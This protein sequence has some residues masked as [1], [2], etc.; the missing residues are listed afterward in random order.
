VST[1]SAELEHVLARLQSILK[2][3]W[4]EHPAEGPVD[5]DASLLS[6]GVDSLTLVTLLDRVEGEFR[7]EW[8]PDNPP[9][10]YSSLHSIASSAVHGDSDSATGQDMRL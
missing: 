3:V 2:E 9:G 7:V 6:L 4:D 5:T 10:A 1:K 8:D